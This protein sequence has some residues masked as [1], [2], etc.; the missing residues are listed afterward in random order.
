MKIRARKNQSGTVYV[1]DLGRD[2]GGRK[3]YPSKA[4]ALRE[5]ERHKKRKAQHGAM[6][7]QL[8]PEEMAEIVAVR[9][10]AAEGGFTLRD[11]VEHYLAHGKRLQSTLLLPELAKRFLASRESMGLSPKYLRQLPV[12][13][14]SLSDRYPLKP[15]HEV[16]VRDVTEWLNSGGWAASTKKNY[17]G[18]AST[19]FAWAMLQAQGFAQINPCVGVE[20]ERRQKRGTVATL[21]NAQA[22]QLLTAALERENWRVLAFCTLGLFCGLRPESEAASP[23]FTWGDIDLDNRTVRLEHQIVK[24]GPGRVV[25][26]PENAVEWLRFIP[27]TLRKGPVVLLKNWPE[28]WMKFRYSLGW[29]VATNKVQKKLALP[30]VEAVH[31]PWPKDVLR[32]TYASNHL[33]HHHDEARLQV[34]MGH[35]SRKMLNEHYLAVKTPKEA[36]QYWSI[37]PMQRAENVVPFVAA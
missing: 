8:T 7:D 20:L 32:H 28:T 21:T 35:A 23:L 5:M 4:E 33:A 10:R 36:A 15:A 26:L 11:A 31:G 2:A 29:Q 24:A 3:T 12:A 27:V 1:L 37:R 14:D 13:L 9:A 16:T 18:N 6:L 30:K 25:S 22:E 19:M 34:Q 17:L